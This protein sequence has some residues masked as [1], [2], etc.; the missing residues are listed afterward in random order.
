MKNTY[1]L[2][3]AILTVAVGSAL[4]EAI[5]SSPCNQAASGSDNNLFCPSCQATS[6]GGGVLPYCKSGGGKCITASFDPPVNAPVT[7]WSANC[8]SYTGQCENVQ[9]SNTT[10][11]FSSGYTTDTGGC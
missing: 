7:L 9:T 3:G 11:E 6:V 8:N 2:I 5:A 10:W 1:L 4:Q